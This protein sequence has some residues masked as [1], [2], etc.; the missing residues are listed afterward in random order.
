MKNLI[1]LLFM[2]FAFSA[3]A[4]NLKP[5]IL[6]SIGVKGKATAIESVYYDFDANNGLQKAVIEIEK[7]D[8][9]GNRISLNRNELLTGK[10][11]DYSYELDKKG[12]LLAEQVVDGT[13]GLTIRSAK[14]DYKKGLVATTTQVEDT[15]TTVKNYIYNG[16]D[17]II[18]VEV[19]ENGEV[20]GVLYNEWDE[21]NRIIKVSQKLSSR[22]TITVNSVFEYKEEGTNDV[23][24]ET[25]TSSNERFLIV[26]LTDKV[27]ELKVQES[28]KDL[29]NNQLN[30]NNYYNVKDA[31][32]SWVKAE[33]LNDQ[34]TRINLVLRKITYADGQITG[35][36]EMLR[37]DDRAQYIRQS[38]SQARVAYN[39]KVVPMTSPNLISG[40]NDYMAYIVSDSATVVLKGYGGN[41]SQTTWHEA[42]IVSNNPDDIFWAA[43]PNNLTVFVKG[44]TINYLGKTTYN[45][46]P[47]S[48]NH[49]E[50]RKKS[51]LAINPGP[52][53]KAGL[54]KA[55]LL[56]HN[57]FWGKMSD[58]TYAL[59]SNGVGVGVIKQSVMP[60]GGRMINTYYGWY[61]LPDFDSKY[62]NGKP[63]DIYVAEHLEEPMKQL[64]V[65]YPSINFNSFVYDK[66]NANEYQLKTVDG[67]KVNS[68]AER[69]TR[70][71]DAKLITYFS[72]T[73][74]YLWMEGYYEKNN[75]QEYLNQPVTV[76][77]KGHESIYYLY[78]D[79]KNITYFARG[80]R[81]T[82]SNFGSTRLKSGET[83]YAAIVYDS[84]SEISYTMQYDLSEKKLIGPM[85]EM[86]YS[87]IKAY[88]VKKDDGGWVVF[89]RGK[90]VDNYDYSIKDNNDVVHFYTNALGVVKAY[91][92]KDFEG[93]K[94]GEF[95]NAEIVTDNDI[96]SL[97][98][99]LKVD[100]SKPK[101]KAAVVKGNPNSFKRTATTYKLWNEN[102]DAISVYL[103]FFGNM[104]SPDALVHDTTRNITYE[105][106]G[107]FTQDNVEGPSKVVISPTDNKVLKWGEK[108]IA[109]FV[110]GEAQQDVRRVFIDNREA[111]EMWSELIYNIPDG[112][113]Y[114]AEY[115]QKEGYFLGDL[116]KLPV[117]DEKVVVTKLNDGKFTF[118]REGQIDKGT[119][120]TANTYQGDLIYVSNG[121]VQKAYRFRGFEKAEY[122]DLLFPEVI[123]P[124]ELSALLK[125][126][127]EAKK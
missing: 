39:G 18:E 76:L 81:L 40:T 17:Q 124:S 98:A 107:Y 65:H 12:N 105:L 82:E 47:N 10:K 54:R 42:D 45:V 108:N 49:L 5:T 27:T 22:D 97:A 102:G 51:F 28:T 48:I 36:T 23:I 41:S 93:L 8:K 83:K 87:A 14:Y 123:P 16:E 52:E 85:K 99:K 62:D 126:I 1:Y 31:N 38:Y 29:G 73:Q 75:S 46:G 115:P 56:D 79:K 66:L 120:F 33:I 70:T 25:R 55:E 119:T 90:G 125:A 63:G 117:D 43:H 60:D 109:L 86:P 113:T 96:T 9:N 127:N 57:D 3:K 95:L 37:E 103:Q 2:V 69:S 118:V 92:F 89:L 61:F 50:E 4:Q 91:R 34:F 20:K 58:S 106:K 44:L 88:I 94:V 64:K 80:K 67:T 77:S 104:G 72:L 74:E 122:L 121:A 110:G 59:V 114:F 26:T 19:I 7:F 78:N 6:K 21:K 13:T 24:S 35:R 112:S 84:I 32:G 11:L 111:S 71:P 101:E 30:I 100:P 53:E 116:K 15:T 68:L